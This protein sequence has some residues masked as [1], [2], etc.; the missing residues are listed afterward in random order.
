MKKFIS[1]A[2]LCIAVS[3]C[4]PDAHAHYP[5][6]LLNKS[7]IA[8]KQRDKVMFFYGRGHMYKREWSKSPK[9]DWVKVVGFDGMTNDIT[10]RLRLDGDHYKFSWQAKSPG[11]T[12]V[13]VHTPLEWSDHDMCWVETTLRSIVHIGFSK[14]WQEPLGLSKLE[15]LPLTRPYGLLPG[16]VMRVK[17]MKSGKSVPNQMVYAERY[18][19]KTP[20]GNEPPIELLMRSAQTDDGGVAGITL[21]KSGWWVIFTVLEDGEQTIKGKKGLVQREDALWVHVE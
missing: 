15:M 20:A 8:V 1:A 11:D 10:S 13:V 3:L 5:I 16:D 9:P 14:G 2:F 4:A 19:S 12:W 7:P 6:L 18:Y 21:R 17:V